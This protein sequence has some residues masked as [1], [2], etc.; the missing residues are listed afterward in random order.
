[1]ETYQIKSVEIQGFGNI[2]HVVM[3]E[4]SDRVILEGVN[5]VG[6]STILMAIRTALEGKTALPDK[7][8][9]EF[10]KDGYENS[11]I[12]L[13]LS[14][15]K[16]VCFSI[17]VIITTNDF[18]LTIKEVGED[19]KSKKI[20]GGSMAFLKTIVNTIAFR[21][22]AW[23]KKNDADQVEEI[24]S[25]FP[26]LKE[27]LSENS[28]KLSDAE[29]ERSGLLA[30]AKVLRLDIDRSL[31]T[32]NLPDKEIDAKELFDKL[33]KAQKH[34]NDL[35]QLGDDFFENESEV[36]QIERTEN[37]ISQEML[38]TEEMIKNLQTQLEKSRK[39]LQSKTDEKSRLVTV[40]LGIQEKIKVFEEIKI[41]P[42]Q[43]EI[44]ELNA[45]NEGVRKNIERERLQKE[46]EDTELKA[47]LKHKD[48]KTID[49]NRTQIMST[50]E[51]PIDGLSIGEGCLL[52][53]NSSMDM[54]RLSALSDG[55]FWPVACGLVA[56]FK[57][58]V[59][60]MIVDNMHD[61]DKNNFEALSE[62]AK[63]Y[64]FQ[65]WVH[66]TLWDEEDAGAGFLI[67]DGQIINGPK[68]S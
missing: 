14:D 24:F 36:R 7:P 51:I 68:G 11:L 65:I 25:F 4:L 18:K 57:P 52:Y 61:L 41:E 37:L 38:R 47:S 50:A 58:K 34:N 19:G 16:T 21:P 9:S 6:K 17:R 29:Q 8:L 15:G 22:Q 53:P 10:V 20:D 40:S 26:G 42:I 54:V 64:G 28:K 60:I 49:D 32:P 59:K 1:M 35:K 31:F 12:K 3:K 33:Q 56:A 46:L 62:S 66:K 27:K 39:D 13:E 67:R 43:K 63:K 5:G 55:E 23:R 30:K 2:G 45:K 44:S 48:I